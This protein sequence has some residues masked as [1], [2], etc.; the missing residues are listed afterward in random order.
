MKML[1][2]GG[3]VVDPATGRDGEFD[4][5]IEDGT[6]ARI[7][8]SLSCMRSALG[9]TISVAPSLISRQRIQRIRAFPK[10]CISL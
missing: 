10:R 5:L 7:G 2:K 6:I 3:R 4:V 9:Q 8:K 1:L